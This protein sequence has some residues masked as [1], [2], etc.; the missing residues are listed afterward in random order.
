M[1][2]CT[3]SH[4][5]HPRKSHELREPHEIMSVLHMENAGGDITNWAEVVK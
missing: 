5:R 4:S 1:H 2:L 3:Q